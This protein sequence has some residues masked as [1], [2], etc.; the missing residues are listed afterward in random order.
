[1]GSR[2]NFTFNSITLLKM[3]L[4]SQSTTLTSRRIVNIS[5]S[6]SDYPYRKKDKDKHYIKNWRPI[7]LLDVDNENYIEGVSNSA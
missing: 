5:K 3:F 4:F 1:M 7:S 6:S 2:E